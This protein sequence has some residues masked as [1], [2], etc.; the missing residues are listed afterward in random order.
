MSA[1]DYLDVADF[2]TDHGIASSADDSA[3]GRC[4][5]DA[6]R[7]IDRLCG[8]EDGHFAAQTFTRYFDV[9]S[10][11]EGDGNAPGVLYVADLLSVTTLKIDED[12]DGVFEVTLTPST[13]YLLYPLNETPKIEVRINVAT[14]SYT[15]PVGQKTVELVG[16]WGE[17]AAVPGPIRRA[18]MIQ[19]NR[20]RWRLRAPEGVAGNAETGFVNLAAVDPDV[21]TI[22]RQG[23]YMQP[24]VFA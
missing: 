18:T 12:G 9:G 14:G 13:D 15:F 10:T 1:S 3:I 16:S 17:A 6:A 2:K 20:Y 7:T 23:G 4:I 19:A 11:R 22:L 8:V 24:V 5:T 21:L